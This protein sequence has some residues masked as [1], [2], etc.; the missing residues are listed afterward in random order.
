VDV[1]GEL[2]ACSMDIYSVVVLIHVTRGSIAVFY[3]SIAPVLANPASSTSILQEAPPAK[4]E[5]NQRQH[6]SR[7]MQESKLCP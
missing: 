1:G 3:F 4:A 2:K 5:F 7:R 6:R